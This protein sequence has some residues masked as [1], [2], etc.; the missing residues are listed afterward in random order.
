[1]L[2]YAVEQEMKQSDTELRSSEE[3][4]PTRLIIRLSEEQR[5]E[6]SR[7]AADRG[8]SIRQYMDWLLNKRS[9]VDIRIAVTDFEAVEKQVDDLITVFNGVASVIIR[10]GKVYEGEL[11]TLLSSMQEI[12][13][14]FK[15]LYREEHDN[16]YRL[17]AECR[18]RVFEDIDKARFIKRNRIKEKG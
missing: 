8:L 4:A 3:A 18:K 2:L 5:E 7:R 17:Y 12:N 15:K 11:K 1:Y 6:I 14:Y 9:D 16:R 13:E 10:S